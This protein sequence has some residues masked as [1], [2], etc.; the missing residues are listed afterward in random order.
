MSFA[1]KDALKTHYNEHHD[2]VDV[3][4][5]LRMIALAAMATTDPFP[6]IGLQ[7]PYS[8]CDQNRFFHS[9][10]GVMDHLKRAHHDR[11]MEVMRQ[12]PTLTTTLKAAQH[13]M[14]SKDVPLVLDDHIIY[15]CPF[16]KNKECKTICFVTDAGAL[17]QHLRSFHGLHR[18]D[19]QFIVNI[20]RFITLKPNWGR[21]RRVNYRERRQR[22]L[23]ALLK[24]RGHVRKLFMKL[25]L[26][27]YSKQFGE[28]IQSN[29]QGEGAESVFA[30]SNLFWKFRNGDGIGI[31][32]QVFEQVMD[33]TINTKYGHNNFPPDEPHGN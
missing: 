19:A 3:G 24:Y 31:D 27:G 29:T 1:S 11:L 28:G 21:W 25:Y 26:R 14:A 12:K 17:M 33:R 6:R 18:D 4:L 22:R 16:T 10:E 7:C 8:D 2:V 15:C 30:D 9:P 23:E 20:I 13:V 32:E 5:E